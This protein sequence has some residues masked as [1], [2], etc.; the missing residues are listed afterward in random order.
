MLKTENQHSTRASTST[1]PSL[2]SADKSFRSR[3]SLFGDLSRAALGT[4]LAA[5]LPVNAVAAAHPDAELLSIL[6]AFERIE[7]RIYPANGAGC[8]TIE[9]EDRRELLI[10]PLHAERRLLAARAC[11]LHATTPAGWRARACTLFLEDL[12]LEPDDEANFC[13]GDRLLH[14]LI[15]DLLE[16]A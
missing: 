5:V 2:T 1:P 16:Q 15:R 9:E 12:E 6:A 8:R 7:K 13:I 11:S 10:A 3:R 4:A 14:A